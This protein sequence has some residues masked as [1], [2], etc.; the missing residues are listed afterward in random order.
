MVKKKDPSMIKEKDT[1][2]KQHGSSKGEVH[3]KNT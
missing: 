3:A 2:K 1:T